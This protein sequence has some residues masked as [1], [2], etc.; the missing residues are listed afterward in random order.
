MGKV[1]RQ[2][3]EYK[4]SSV[5][6]HHS[7]LHLHFLL[8]NIINNTPLWAKQWSKQKKSHTVLFKI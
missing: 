1:G 3:F 7:S 8:I 2:E 4:G 5:A 6:M